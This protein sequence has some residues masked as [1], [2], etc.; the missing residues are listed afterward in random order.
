MDY[1]V[2]RCERCRYGRSSLQPRCEVGSRDISGIRTQTHPCLRNTNMAGPFPVNPTFAKERLMDRHALITSCLVGIFGCAAALGQG[3]AGGAG[4]SGGSGGA[5]ST[6]MPTSSSGTPASSTSAP[7]SASGTSQTP[8][9]QTPVQQ[10]RTSPPPATPTPATNQTTSPTPSQ[11]TPASTTGTIPPNAST[12]GATPP[13]NTDQTQPSN[14]A[15]SDMVDATDPARRRTAEAS[16]TNSDTVPPAARGVGTTG[17]R[18]DCRQ[19]RGLEK[20]E[21]ERRDTSR[22][23]LPAGVTTTQPSR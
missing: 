4:T 17:N 19:M 8:G 16:T 1:G 22:D 11:S 13:N 2:Q 3:T 14:P 10:P 21:C 7:T 6:A 23:D 12:A 18:P 15:R 9:T 20:S 5:Q